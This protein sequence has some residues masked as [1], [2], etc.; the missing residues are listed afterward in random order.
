MKTCLPAL[1]LLSVVAANS[2]SAQSAGATRIAA[3]N[4]IIQ[5]TLTQS[6]LQAMQSGQCRMYLIN[7]ANAT[8]ERHEEFEKDSLS[9]SPGKL[10][11]LSAHRQ[12]L[13][14]SLAHYQDLEDP[15]A[16]IREVEV[17][18]A[19]PLSAPATSTGETPPTAT[20]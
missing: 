17:V 15:C 12:D 8:Y 4:A 6:E 14:T 19:D 1:L 13:D 16:F 20:R 3:L 10:S 18:K 7:K 9:L 2:V 5:E 11:R